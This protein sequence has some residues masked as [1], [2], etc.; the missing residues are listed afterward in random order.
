MCVC[1]FCVFL[2]PI[3]QFKEDFTDGIYHNSQQI[4]VYRFNA[5]ISDTCSNC[6]TKQI[7]PHK[8][9]RL[10]FDLGFFF[11]ESSVN[12]Q[13]NAHT[14][15]DR[16]LELWIFLYWISTCSLQINTFTPYIHIVLLRCS[17]FFRHPLQI[18]SIFAICK[19][20]KR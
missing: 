14:I 17:Y 5:L 4:R 2:W 15:V 12:W 6:H 16:I 18:N 3:T 7:T 13:F 11:S 1:V 19:P 20:N 10:Y 9:F 8:W